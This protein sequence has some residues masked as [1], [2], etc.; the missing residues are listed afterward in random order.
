[1][2]DFKPIRALGLM[3]GTSMDGVDAAVL[4]TDGVDIQD[5]GES[6]FRPFTASE[7]EILTAAQSLWPEEEP[8]I[9]QTA[10]AVI[11]SAHADIVGEFEDIDLIGFH[12]QTLNHDPENARTFQLGNGINFAK[13]T[14]IQTAWD[15]RT[16]DMIAG[17]QGA[18]LAPFFHFACAKWAGLTIPTAFLNLGGVGN[19][20]LIDPRKP[21]PDSN[22][23]LLAFD[24]GPANAPLNDL[25]QARLNKPYDENGTLA[26][27]GTVDEAILTRVF[28]RAFFAQKPPKSLDRHDFHDALSLVEH[29]STADAA[30]TLTAL[31]AACVAANQ[32]HLPIQPE[33]WYICGGGAQ[34]PTL[35]HELQTR[36][37]GQV[38]PI[39]NIA[40]DGDMLEAQAFAFLAVRTLRGLPISA[41]STTG[42]LKPQ[43]GGQIATP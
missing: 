28:Q 17:G 26:A 35:M 40:L 10:L 19:V 5:F 36:L 24:T 38:L 16:A 29:L 25:M 12:G 33:D 6:A 11:Q 42:C 41:P 21:T 9:L 22:G 7:V 34:N 13:R 43:R 23:A 39:E 31:P 37:T 8:E 3:S 15:F 32:S 2:A 27:T 1:L 30:A 18:P 14:G 20:T 4:L